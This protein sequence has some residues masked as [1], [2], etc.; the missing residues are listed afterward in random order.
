MIYTYR[1]QAA[2]DQMGD[3]VV[4]GSGQ[5]FA[6]T[7]A[8]F[9]TPL[10]VQD[11]AGLSSTTIKVSGIGQTNTFSI[12]GHPELWWKSGQYIAHIFSITGLLDDSAA[13]AQAATAAADLATQAALGVAGALEKA[14]D[15]AFARDHKML[16][17]SLRFLRDQM[18]PFERG[19][20]GS[21]VR[22]DRPYSDAWTGPTSGV[23]APGPDPLTITAAKLAIA[24]P[25]DGPAA[26]ARGMVFGSAP[27]NGYIRVYKVGDSRYDTGIVAQ[28]DAAGNWAVDLTPVEEWRKGRWEFQ[29]QTGTAASTAVGPAIGP[30]VGTGAYYTDLTAQLRVITDTSY[31]IETAKVRADGTFSFYAAAPGRKQVRIMQAP[32]VLLADWTPT[33]G[34]ARSYVVATGQPGFG[35]GFALQSYVY[36]QALALSAAVAAQD[37]EMSAALALGLLKFQNHDGAD[38]GGFIFS[39]PQHNPSIGDKMYRTGAHAVAVYALLQYVEAYPGT[40]DV[41]VF[42]AIQGLWWLDGYKVATAG[43][44][45]GL[46]KGGKGTYTVPFPGG[47]QQP[48]MTY[49]VTWCSTEHNLDAY[50]AY[51]LADR[52]LPGSGYGAQAAALKDAIMA[53]LWNTTEGR[54]NQGVQTTGP[55]TADALDLHSWGA[56]FLQAIG[57]TTKATDVMSVAALAPFAITIDGIGGYGIADPAKG[58]PGMVPNVWSEGSFGVALALKRIGEPERRGFLLDEIRKMQL[59]TGGW[60]YVLRSDPTY[61]LTPYSSVAGAAW[62][63]LSQL[64]GIWT[65]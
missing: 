39:G 4:D 34:A 42:P 17:G 56:I 11:S 52:V 41:A 8:A 16:Y 60:P 31:V 21:T 5:V 19:V 55:D 30:S 50:W 33:T 12:E 25:A 22:F 49:N 9:T 65:P 51:R 36:D 38:Q 62:S 37:E 43:T 53:K 28:A 26:S 47:G 20:D 14:V 1:T 57:E 59:P 45:E 18:K 64:D 7:D 61:E 24:N 54:F 6:I 46:L 23:F 32:G 63:V 35:T 27:A 3:L 15:R 2:I 44:M 48:N 40:S 10:T 58:Y 13:S 29:Y